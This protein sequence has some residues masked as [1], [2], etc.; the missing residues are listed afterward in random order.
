LSTLPI[1]ADLAPAW[2]EEVNRRLALHKSRMASS[3]AAGTAAAQQAGQRKSSGRGR[4]AAAAA[5]VAARYAKAPSYSEMLAEEARAAVRAAETASRAALQAQAAAESILAGLEADLEANFAADFDAERQAGSV[6]GHDFSR[7]A[8]AAE[9][10]WALAPEGCPPP[11]LSEIPSRSA[12]CFAPAAASESAADASPISRQI[13]QGKSS[14][15]SWVA[16][17]PVLS[18][19]A[20][21]SLAPHGTN[22]TG[23][24]LDEGWEPQ[25][26][27]HELAG[28]DDRE[29]REEAR[30]M[31]QPLPANLIEFPRELIAARRIRP[32]LVE[33]PYAERDE[34]QLS[35]FE[36]DPGTISTVPELASDTAVEAAVWQGAHWS[37]MELEEEP[38]AKPIV[39]S[40]AET[41][42][43]APELH[44]APFGLRAMAAVVDGALILGVF[45]AVALAVTTQMKH[46]P[47]KQQIE[48]GSAVALLILGG[49]Y[50]ILFFTLAQ[51]TPGMKYAHISL[52]TFDDENPTRAQLRSR[53][54]ALLLSLLPLGLGVLWAI[55]DED[56]LSWHDRLSA[57][58]Q[59]HW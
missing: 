26:W 54:V 18:R 2:K 41:A 59:R 20:A 25:A 31:F 42:A 3:S 5:R 15:I 37:G 55:F 34:R 14:G 4:Q 7:A 36:V 47:S 11:I 32:R 38:A 52:C 8:S 39:K 46:L 43:A 17:M 16:D 57:T 21:A 40:P 30:A 1:Q 33:G 29:A 58:Y 49:V 44:L 22:A 53:M 56:H 35:I 51:S 10:T 28:S 48:L 23:M 12:T 50:Q 45:L 24:A 27:P 13:A 6:S 19:E 9:S